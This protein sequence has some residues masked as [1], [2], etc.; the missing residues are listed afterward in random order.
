MSQRVEFLYLSAED[1]RAAGGADMVATMAACEQAFRL[2]EEGQCRE[3]PT[4]KIHWNGEHAHRAGPKIAYVGGQVNAVGVKWIP[5]NPDNPR[6]RHLPR[7]IAQIIL[8]DP[9]SAVPRAIMDGTIISAVRTAAV[10]GIFAK[11]LAK[12]GAES[13]SV[14]GTGPIGRHQLNAILLAVPS[15]RRVSVYDLIPERSEKFVADKR[16]EFPHL[17]FQVAGSARECIEAGDIIAT[18]TVT[19]PEDAYIEYEWLRPGAVVINTSSNDTKIDTFRKAPRLVF[20][21]SNE[22]P[23]NRL[24]T[25]AARCYEEG[26]LPSDKL[27]HISEIITGKKPARLSPDDIIISLPMGMAIMD[28]INAQRVYERARELGIGRTLPL[29]EEVPWV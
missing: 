6:E 26:I 11:Y 16:A 8:T 14:I 29:W 13:V 2:F 27:V 15:I 5:A 22:K 17:E 3:L 7:A 19:A 4:G 24:R 12:P 18:A 21:Y 23:G 20:S 1:V 25:D 10:G 9:V 28:I